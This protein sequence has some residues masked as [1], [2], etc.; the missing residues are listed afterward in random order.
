MSG[1][2]FKLT[3]LAVVCLVTLL[4]CSEDFELT[5]KWKDIP[6]VYGFLNRADSAH[7]IRLE[8]VFVSEDISASTIAKNADSLY[9]ND[10]FVKLFNLSTR[11]E[12]ILTRVDASKEGYTRDTGAFA[13]VPNYMYKL[14]KIAGQF[15]SNDSVMLII[16]RQNGLPLVTAKIKM[17]KDLVFSIP[18]TSQNIKVLSF[19]PDNIQSFAWA[20]S[21]ASL[22]SFDIIIHVQEKNTQ[23]GAIALKSIK[24]PKLRDAPN[25]SVTFTNNDFY[26]ALASQL[27]VDPNITRFL[28]DVSLDLRAGGPEIQSLND[29]VSANTGVTASQEIPR[30]TNL[31][32]GYG[33][34]SST[35]SIV[36]AMNIDQKTLSEIRKNNSTRLLNF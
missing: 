5:E 24:L 21:D 30:Y 13:T 34:F 29:L 10:A 3:V 25:K 36:L 6:V 8:K 26:D 11:N 20:T 32:A 16:D 28:K 22:F 4:G 1:F 12:F 7:Y 2:N 18:D 23:T 14:P 35:H 17:I 27:T 31:S 33:I 9:Y 15:H 19:V